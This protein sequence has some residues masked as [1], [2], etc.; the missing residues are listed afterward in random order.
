GRVFR[1]LVDGHLLAMDAKTGKVIWD[2]VGAGNPGEFYT[3]APIAW[4]GRVYIGNAGSDYGAIG[5]LRAFDAGTGKMLWN[6]D[7][8]ASTGEAGKTWPNDTGRVRAGGGTYSSY[9]L[10]TQ[11]GL[12]YSP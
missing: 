9:A 4:E 7:T 5:H 10:D 12:L 8:V 3:S 6:F 2:V 1:G 11:A